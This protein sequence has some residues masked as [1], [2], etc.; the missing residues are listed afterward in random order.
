MVEHLPPTTGKL[1]APTILERMTAVA[2]A[3]VQEHART[4]PAHRCMSVSFGGP[5]CFFFFDPFAAASPALAPSA[6]CCCCDTPG[7]P[8]VWPPPGPL[9]RPSKQTQHRTSIPHPTCWE[10]PLPVAPRTLL[11][12]CVT[13]SVIPGHGLS[14]RLRAGRAGSESKPT[15][16]VESRSSEKQQPGAWADLGFIYCLLYASV[17]TLTVVS[18]FRL[19]PCALLPPHTPPFSLHLRP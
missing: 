4:H 12:L 2:C 7:Y 3:V 1:D 5:K 16:K 13:P 8:I 10:L 18:G 19:A 11:L 17:L 14:N 15:E 6:C 9:S